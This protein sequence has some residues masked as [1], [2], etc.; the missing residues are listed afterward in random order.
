MFDRLKGEFHRQDDASSTA[1]SSTRPP[2]PAYDGPPPNARPT[3]TSKETNRPYERPEPTFRTNFGSVSLHM[4]DRIRLMGLPPEITAAIRSTLQQTW[5]NGIQDER[6]Y[7]GSVEFK[8][9]GYPWSPTGDDAIHARR[10]TRGIMAT[11]YS[12]GWVLYISTDI[13]RKPG[14]KD[15]LFFRHQDPPPAPREW[16][17]CTFSKGD[18]IRLIDAPESVV[19]DMIRTLQGYIQTHRPYHVSGTY[20][21]KL[22][23]SP[24]AASGGE[25]MVSRVLCLE[26]FEVLER[27]G[28]TL[29]ASIDQKYGGQHGTETDSWQ[30]SRPVGWSPGAPVYHQ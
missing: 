4:G 23:G 3:S 27:N 10:V 2:P 11:L 14:D 19:Q 29:Y 8:L 17:S 24:F 6:G 28:F 30:M 25:T 26:L 12:H 16:F 9:R 13:S 1:G 5:P 7:H 22:N 15:N 18:R 21:I 20:E